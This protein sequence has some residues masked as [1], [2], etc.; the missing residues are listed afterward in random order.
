MQLQCKGPHF[1]R[2]PQFA[3]LESPFFSMYWRATA[4]WFPWWRADQRRAWANRAAWANISHSACL[5][6]CEPT[7]AHT[8][9]EKR[10]YSRC[11]SRQRPHWQV[12]IWVGTIPHTGPA[13]KR[14]EGCWLGCV[15]GTR[16][17][18]KARVRGAVLLRPQETRQKHQDKPWNLL[19]NNPASKGPGFPRWFTVRTE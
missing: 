4:R 15:R 5:S 7:G 14:G 3:S 16:L 19:N 2:L 11:Q 9:A 18:Q 12:S 1:T 17:K 13:K 10:Y 8:L 6:A